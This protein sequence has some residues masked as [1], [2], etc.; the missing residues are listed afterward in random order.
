MQRRPNTLLSLLLAI[1]S[2]AGT[3]PAAG[4]AELSPCEPERWAEEIAQFRRHDA[5]SPPPAGAVVF[6]G[7][8]SIRLWDLAKSF[9][10]LAAINRGF[11]GSHLCDAVHYADLLVAN[12][13]PSKIVLYAGDNDLAAGKT[14]DQVLGDFQQFVAEIRRSSAETPIIFIAIKPS[15]DRW[16]LRAEQQRANRLIAKECGAGK[17][18]HFVDVW[19]AMLG[20]DGVPRAQFFQE[21]GLH[22]NDAGYAVWTKLLRPLLDTAGE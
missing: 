15:P 22:L 2:A 14:A 20:A 9:P 18:L 21:D 16:K 12:H 8:S 7:S 6:V 1:V 10:G 13:Q 3:C 17:N 5:E 11:G 4:G 19:Q